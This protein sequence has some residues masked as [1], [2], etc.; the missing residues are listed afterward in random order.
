MTLL[1]SSLPA[2]T[3]PYISSTSS[4]S[5]FRHNPPMPPILALIIVYSTSHPLPYFVSCSSTTAFLCPSL[6]WFGRPGQ[7]RRQQRTR[8]GVLPGALCE[9]LQERLYMCYQVCCVNTCRNVCMCYRF[10]VWIFA[11]ALV[12]VIGC[13]VWIFAGMF[14]CAIGALCEYLQE[15]LYVLSGVLY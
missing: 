8:R 10:V 9:Y 4:I 6:A 11:G 15:R 12:C 2:T 5:N 14:V 7:R 3:S 1:C 13:V